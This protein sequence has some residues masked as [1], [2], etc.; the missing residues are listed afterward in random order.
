MT[1]LV[2]GSTGNIGR[3][4]LQ[5]LEGSGAQVRALM[6]D[7]SKVQLPAGMQAVAG[8]FSDPASIRAAFHGV[9]TLFLLNA[10][11]ADEVTQGLTAL[12]LARE[13]GIERIVYFSVLNADRF[14]SVPHFT[15]KYTVERMIEQFDLP[16]TVLRPSYFMQ[17]DLGLKQA[18]QQGVYPSPVGG[19]G[20]AMVDTGDIAQIAAQ[21]LLR[22]EQAASPLPREVIELTGPQALTGDALAA[23][24]S[25]ALGKPIAYGG[26]D[27]AA[28]EANAVQY[29]PH[30]A[31]YDLRLMVEAFQRDGM[32]A[33]STGLDVM[34][35]LLG[36]APRSYQDFAQSAVAAWQ[37]EG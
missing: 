9:D 15:G 23:I 28:F 12:N 10:V 22:R 37:A 26:D 2:S 17:N 32:L 24:W 21:A 34:T 19:V 6:R 31:A 1:I 29:M 30:W 5:Q 16:A 3:Q 33:K 8:D 35:G 27:S 7:P 36:R 25:Q 11:V 20:V 14:S 18:L 4:V 13:A